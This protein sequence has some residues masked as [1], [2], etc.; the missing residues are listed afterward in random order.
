M[1][2]VGACDRVTAA[3]ERERFICYCYLC[4]AID[5][6]VERFSMSFFV[7]CRRDVNFGSSINNKK[8]SASTI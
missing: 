3:G 1:G 4:V 8:G 6:F 5:F 7:A 2:L